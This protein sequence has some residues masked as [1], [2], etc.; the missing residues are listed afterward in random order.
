M[1]EPDLRT[2]PPPRWNTATGGVIWLTRFAA[3]VR[4][5]DAGTLGTYLLGQSPIDDEFL[6]AAQLDYAAFMAIVRAAPG[7]DE[8]LA[9][10]EAR[11]PGST[12]RLQLW[13]T[14][15]PVRRRLHLRILDLDDGYDRPAWFAVPHAV[16]GAL[17]TR[18]VPILRALRPL[19]S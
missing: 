7:D 10:I 8:V 11:A 18:L 5:H 15:M 2:T 13:S 1:A 16:A 19:K 9:A 6:A 17:F 14:E 4:A 3:K 12:A